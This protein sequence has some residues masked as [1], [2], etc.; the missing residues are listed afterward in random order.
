METFLPLLFWKFLLIN[1]R[2]KSAIFVG[3]SR[4]RSDEKKIVNYAN[5]AICIVKYSFNY[6][7][8]LINWN[9]SS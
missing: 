2:L 6:L 8:I 3:A 9:F 4:L 1:Q 7:L 5:M